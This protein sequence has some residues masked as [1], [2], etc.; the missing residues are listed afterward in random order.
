LVERLLAVRR[1]VKPSD[2]IPSIDTFFVPRL[3]NLSLKAGK[4]VRWNK[5][6][7]KVEA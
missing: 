3:A 1:V 4:P 2:A 5:T 7:R 6:T